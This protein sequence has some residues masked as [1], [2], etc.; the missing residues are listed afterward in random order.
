M[1]MIEELTSLDDV[2]FRLNGEV[3]STAPRPTK[4]ILYNEYWLDFDVS[5]APAS[6]TGPERHRLIEVMGRN[7]KHR[8]SSH[9]GEHGG[10]RPLEVIVRYAGQS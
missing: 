9:R 1:M 8:R 7:P 5:G 3:G 10:H 2:E 4:H 6:E